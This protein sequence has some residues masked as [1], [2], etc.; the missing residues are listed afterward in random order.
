M[1]LELAHIY[2]N[3]KWQ[4][5]YISRPILDLVESLSPPL[6]GLFLIF[7]EDLPYHI[8]EISNHCISS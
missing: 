5:H 2:I 8:S 1:G 6:V 7:F 3:D 4:S